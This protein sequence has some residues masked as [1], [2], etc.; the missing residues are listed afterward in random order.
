MVAI[1]PYLLAFFNSFFVNCVSG[2]FFLSI[3][4]NFVPQLVQNFSFSCIS[5][6]QLGQWLF[7]VTL[8][9]DNFTMN[10]YYLQL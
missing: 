8:P 4:S 7:I 1:M 2:L 3:F 10:D 6:L 5:F 9:Y